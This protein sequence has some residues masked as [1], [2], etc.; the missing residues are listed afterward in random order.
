[1]PQE[2]QQE[3]AISTAEPP[4]NA[5]VAGFTQPGLAG[6]TGVEFLVDQLD[7]TETGHVTASGLPTLT[8]FEEG[9]PRHHTRMLSHDDIDVT[10]LIGEL[11][12]P[13][14][15]ATTF[16]DAILDWVESH[17]TDEIAI[18]SGVPVPHGPDDHQTFYVATEDFLSGRLEDTSITPM[19]NGFLDG[20]NAAL[21]ERGMSSDLQVGVLV[22]PVHALTPDVDAAIRLVEAVN[23]LYQVDVDT[24]PL[25]AFGE[26]VAGYYSELQEHLQRRTEDRDTQMPE[27]RM[28]M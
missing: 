24:G 13:L 11:F 3:F 15:A 10:V 14:Q 8:P 4:S 18:L 12:V 26:E 19:G 17:D 23:D 5:I 7:L 22:T 6:L 21:V 25:E 9:R 16:S 28:F 20:I 2:S 1:M 27:D